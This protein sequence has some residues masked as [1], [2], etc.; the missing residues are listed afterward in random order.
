[1]PLASLAPLHGGLLAAGPAS[2][3]RG[4]ASGK[5]K[6][7][8]KEGPKMTQPKIKYGHGAQ[9][10]PSPALRREADRAQRVGAAAG[11]GAAPPLHE[12][13]PVLSGLL[14][15][16]SNDLASPPDLKRLSPLVGGVEEPFDVGVVVAT[17]RFAG[18]P[19]FS[20]DFAGRVLAV[21]TRE[22]IEDGTDQEDEDGPKGVRKVA[23]QRAAVDA[24][25]RARA[26]AADAPLAPHLPAPLLPY[27]PQGPAG[28]ARARA[29]EMTASLLSADPGLARARA[30]TAAAAAGG[31]EGEEE[32]DEEEEGEGK[33]KGLLVDE[34]GE[35]LDPS[36]AMGL[37]DGGRL[38]GVAAALAR[39]RRLVATP[40][41]RLR[42]AAMWDE[43]EGSSISVLG[44]DD[45]EAIPRG[46]LEEFAQ[47]L[48]FGGYGASRRQGP[49]AGEA[50]SAREALMTPSERALN[51]KRKALRAMIEAPVPVATRPIWPLYSLI[52]G[53]DTVRLVTSGGVVDSIRC[54]VVVGNGMGGVG[55]GLGKHKDAFDSTRIA[56]EKATRDM[57]HLATHN[58]CLY[59]DLLGK[60]NGVRVLLRAN[61]ATGG[62]VLRGAPAIVD[63]LE[64]AGVKSA[65]AK[66][67]GS[68][69]RNPYVVMQA[70]FD[71]FNHHQSPEEE[72]AKRGLRLLRHT[73]D[74]ANPRTVY[75]FN[76]PGPRF[77]PANHRFVS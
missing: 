56:L 13:D 25:R 72:A 52:A 32:E 7:N 73:V 65:S 36:A 40:S 5:G 15:G 58:G 17:H 24:M 19:K 47:P 76:P 1:M 77:P 69:R 70:L 62:G 57:I 74:R 26:I 55:V 41:E 68:H 35:L 34:D 46:V 75:P 66:I 49:G 4:L 16:A 67:F 9:D 60:K 18:V 64:L 59:H 51:E 6:K 28:E 12:A 44:G 53:V 31:G 48:D 27:L 23:A 33:G 37:H 10:R 43:D 22:D 50:P 21:P 11:G 3:A 20:S 71:A 61:P 39:G 2:G 8:K 14:E 38:A 45:P 29:E 42:A 30:S 54:M 63:V